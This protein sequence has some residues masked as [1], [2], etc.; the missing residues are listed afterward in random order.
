M[1]VL[2][3]KEVSRHLRENFKDEVRVLSSEK[4]R[5]PG[6]AVIIVGEDPASKVYV[7]SKI[8]ACKT[9]GIKSF[10][11]KESA[12]ITAK[13]LQ[14]RIE[15][16]NKNPDVDGI[17]VQLPLPQSLK[18]EEV[19]SWIDPNKDA[20]C[21]TAENLG[22]LWT[23]RPRTKPCTPAGVMEILRYYKI[24][25]KGLKVA[26]VGRSQ[27][28]GK[29]M[30]LMLSDADA[31]VTL[32][33]SKTQNVREILKECDLV[34]AAAGK[35]L[36]LGKEDFKKGAVVI[37]VGIHRDQGKLCG[38]VRFDELKGHAYA[39]TPVP[40]GVGPMTITMLLKNTIELF[41]LH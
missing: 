25:P 13:E 31:T 29:P 26:V 28:V 7:A 20:D 11:F 21:L 8:K 38:D 3:G 1:Q 5:P 2:D 19:L 30:S 27:I 36:L 39:A 33:H 24:D 9:V 40:G 37:D 10:E 34:V 12:H 32:C 23:G 14:A 15:G 6:L 17:L 35:P 4:G 41:K 18:T 22:L 16:L